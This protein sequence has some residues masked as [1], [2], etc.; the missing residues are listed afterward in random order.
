MILDSPAP[1]DEIV[2]SANGFAPKIALYPAGAKGRVYA[3]G[4]GGIV[5]LANTPEDRRDAAWQFMRYLLQ[6]EQIAHYAERSGYTAFTTTSQQTAGG[7][8]QDEQRAI[9]HSAL[10]HLR[11]DFSVNVSPAIRTA[12][13]EAFQRIMIKLD[14]PRTALR[15]ADKQAE[16]NIQDELE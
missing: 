9:I 2:T 8:L 15:D 3:P 16:K 7:W 6:P 5:M 1:F 4:G 14:D 10:P 11:G 12:F 13:D